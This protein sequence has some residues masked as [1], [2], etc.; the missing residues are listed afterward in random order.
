MSQAL[1]RAG[2]FR[3]RITDYGL[4]EAKSGA[5]AIYMKAIIEEAFVDG[6]WEDWKSYDVE[7]EGY[8]YIVKKDETLNTSLIE[9]VMRG[10]GWNGNFASIVDGTWQPTP[11]QISCDANEYN[12]QTSYR[13]SW[14]DDWNREP[15][16]GATNVA[17]DKVKAL[18]AKYG[19]QFRALAGKR[20][21]AAPSNGGPKTPP[22]RTA[23]PANVTRELATTAANE[24]VA[25]GDVPF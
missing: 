5:V 7:T 23:P 4:N 24:A 3:C 15:K 10:T 25:T 14:V 9:A 6:E 13:I 1:D 17:P 21:P 8:L 18:N 16:G 20:Q 22:A 12:G 19:S 11:C 2:I